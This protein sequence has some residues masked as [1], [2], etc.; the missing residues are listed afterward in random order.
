MGF[1]SLIKDKVKEDDDFIQGMLCFLCAFLS[2]PYF[3]FI[4]YC[5]SKVSDEK[6]GRVESDRF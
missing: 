3:L 6:S 4:T 1:S 5:S 2:F